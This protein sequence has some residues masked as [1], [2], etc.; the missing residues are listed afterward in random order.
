MGP[1][2]P[3]EDES[4][5]PE[6]NKR[7]DMS[8]IIQFARIVAGAAV[9]S[10]G[11]GRA[12]GVP[13]DGR[14]NPSGSA[15]AASLATNNT[16]RRNVQVVNVPVT[17]LDKRGIPVIDL[18]KDDFKVYE[19]GKL[20]SIGYFT[21]E[22]APPLRIG[23]ILDT[24]NAMRQQMQ[25]E[26][27]AASDFV[28]NILQS[29]NTQ[30]EIFLETFDQSSSII[31]DFTADP[32]VLNDK[33]RS[34][35]AGGGKSL[36]DAIYSACR[37]KMLSAGSPEETRRVLVV[38]SDGVDLQSTHTLEE[39]LSMAHR[40]ETAIYTIG[41]SPYGYD[42]P[43]D[44]I[45]RQLAQ[46]TGGAAFFPLEKEPGADL[47]T[48]YLSHGQ[49]GDTS[50]NKGLG[51]ETGIYNAERMVHLADALE[52]I[53]HELGNQYFIGYTPTHFALDGTYRSIR[54]VVDRK[55]LIVRSKPGYFAIA[56]QA[57]APP[58]AGKAGN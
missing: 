53:E 8:R 41:N 56:Q 40:A 9:I 34:L 27:D 30:N 57:A 25:F 10:M 16:I 3:G 12:Y 31:Q 42:N 19:D 58:P 18:T 45:L 44:K 38:I 28:F 35:K 54:V 29:T 1:G 15:G 51:A 43:A 46:D 20:Q 4:V 13:Q 55:G 47:A 32:Q 17:V 2:Q 36:Y 24:S 23:L 22:P 39:T 33:I 48:G 6:S 50:Q 11:I 49:I 37:N 7:A 26:K 14:R 52:S 5:V 21:R